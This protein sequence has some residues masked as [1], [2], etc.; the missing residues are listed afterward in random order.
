MSEASNAAGLVTTSQVTDASPAGFVAHAR[1]RGQQSEIA[2]QYIEET[3]VDVIYSHADSY[4]YPGPGSQLLL[5]TPDTFACSLPRSPA[6][7][8]LFTPEMST[9]H[10]CSAPSSY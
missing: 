8:A 10:I 3:K 6:F 5:G 9:W 1:G 2:R 4:V 7:S